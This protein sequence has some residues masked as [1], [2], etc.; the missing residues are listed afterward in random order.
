MCVTGV[1]NV[2]VCSDSSAAI[3]GILAH[4]PTEHRSNQIGVKL[5]PE[6]VVRTKKGFLSAS[7]SRTFL[8]VSH[9]VTMLFNFLSTCLYIQIC[10]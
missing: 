5:E 2:G 8:E 4:C 1:R 10:V 6:D 7:M 9:F 3:A